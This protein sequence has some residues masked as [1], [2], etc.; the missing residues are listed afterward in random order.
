MTKLY[1]KGQSI[2]TSYILTYVYNLSKLT[3]QDWKSNTFD[4]TIFMGLFKDFN[5]LNLHKIF[6]LFKVWLCT[7][8]MHIG[9]LDI[10]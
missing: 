10:L 2:Y 3:Y 5:V 8:T 9:F 4:A 7:Y 6:D 1:A